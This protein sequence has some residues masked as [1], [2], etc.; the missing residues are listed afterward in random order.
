[1]HEVGSTEEII[2]ALAMLTGTVADLLDLT[3]MSKL[4]SAGYVQYSNYNCRCFYPV[5]FQETK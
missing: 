2:H 4:T 5:D 3:G 1:M